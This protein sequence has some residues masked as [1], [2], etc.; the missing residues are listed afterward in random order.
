[1]PAAS[2]AT[3]VALRLARIAALVVGSLLFLYVCEFSDNSGSTGWWVE[4]GIAAGFGI[5]GL[6]AGWFQITLAHRIGE[7]EFLIT[8][9][10]RTVSARIVTTGNLVFHGRD[11]G[12]PHPEYEWTW[13]FRPTSFSAIRAAL[14]GGDGDLIA[15]LEDAVPDLDQHYRHDPGAWLRHHDIPA[16][17]R[18]KGV[19]P[20]H[21]TRKLPVIKP[22]P[23]QPISSRRNQ[24]SPPHRDKSSTSRRRQARPSHRDQPPPAHDDQPPP[25]HSRTAPPRREQ[26]RR[27]SSEQPPSHLDQP[28]PR[29]KQAP[30][31][32]R[33]QPMS[34]RDEAPPSQSRQGSRRNLPPGTEESG[35]ALPRGTSDRSRGR[36][37]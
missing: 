18:E 14:G 5:A 37:R 4:I 32:P 3:I 31:V 27:P 28:P 25:H 29:R 23:P 7:H 35:A 26:P 20:T 17:Y 11:L 16:R 30:P 8:S 2:A 12:D 13:T 19:D 1:M 24:S 21:P 33:E 15:L 34:R 9:D 36:H 22:V 6:I 10:G